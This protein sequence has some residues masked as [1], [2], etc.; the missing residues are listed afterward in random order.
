MTGRHQAKLSKRITAEGQEYLEK[1][2]QTGILRARPAPERRGWQAAG[3]AGRTPG[4][5]F[6]RAYDASCGS[7]PLEILPGHVLPARHPAYCLQGN[8]FECC[9]SFLG[10]RWRWK[11]LRKKCSPPKRR[12]RTRDKVAVQRSGHFASSVARTGTLLEIR[13]V[14]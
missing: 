1:D 11:F 4:A 7:L 3:N 5:T 12:S 10:G 8:G 13:L 2:F 14:N 9:S 6:L